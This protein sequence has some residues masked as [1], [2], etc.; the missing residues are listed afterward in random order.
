MGCEEM[1]EEEIRKEL[2]AL[3]ETI[4]RGVYVSMYSPGSLD[5]ALE[6]MKKLE[7]KKAELEKLLND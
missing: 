1:T 2:E 4:K 7:E 6:R 3:E 5:R